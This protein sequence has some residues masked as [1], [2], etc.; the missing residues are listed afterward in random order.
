MIKIVHIWMT[1][2]GQRSSVVCSKGRCVPLEPPHADPGFFAMMA[3][4]P[5][6]AHDNGVK[7]V[8]SCK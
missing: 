6:P 4:K 5:I 3:A 8:I 7:A 2:D 1:M